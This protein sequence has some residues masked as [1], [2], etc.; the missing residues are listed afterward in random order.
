MDSPGAQ[1]AGRSAWLLTRVGGIAIWNGNANWNLM[2]RLKFNKP[3]ICIFWGLI[4]LKKFLDKLNT[5]T[6]TERLVAGRCVR[7]MH[8]L[9]PLLLRAL[10]AVCH[11]HRVQETSRDP[12]RP[13]LQSAIRCRS[14]AS[15]LLLSVSGSAGARLAAQFAINRK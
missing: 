8:S 3:N 13:Q 6:A 1:T 5:L 10:T 12:A 7:Y 9:H 11:I 15:W 14:Y 4:S 2:I